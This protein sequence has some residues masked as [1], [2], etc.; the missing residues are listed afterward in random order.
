LFEPGPPPESGLGA[1][2]DRISPLRFWTLSRYPNFVIVYRPDLD[3]FRVVAVLN[4]KR[5][6]RSVLDES[7]EF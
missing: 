6:L 2:G 4:G 3:P 1:E 7:G 5:D